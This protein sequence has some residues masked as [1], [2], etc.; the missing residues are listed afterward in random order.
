M[1]GNV[2]DLAVGI[3]IGGAFGKIVSSFVGDILMPPIGLLLGKV[4]FA[5]LFISLSDKSFYTLQE[6]PKRQERQ[7][8]YGLFFNSILDFVIVAFA[9]FLMIQQINRLKREEKSSSSSS[10]N[11]GMSFLLFNYPDPG[12]Q[13]R[14]VHIRSEK[15]INDLILNKTT[16]SVQA[17]KEWRRCPCRKAQRL[18]P[19]SL[20]R[21]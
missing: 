8:N 4:D 16:S 6:E 7:L 2:V 10:R 15:V 20:K 3:I 12:S 18:R 21:I 5:N 19:R 13:V 1:K 17:N 11:Q 14:A 9:I